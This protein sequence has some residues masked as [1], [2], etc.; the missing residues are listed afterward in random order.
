MLEV[1]NPWLW[2]HKTR[3]SS[4]AKLCL[5]PWCPQEKGSPGL[6]VQGQSLSNS[7]V[8]EG[9]SDITRALPFHE[10]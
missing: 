6:A 5:H 7:Y 4:E 8:S 3:L 9:N 10:P 2:I 1:N